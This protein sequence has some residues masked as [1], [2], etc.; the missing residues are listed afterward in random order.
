M[1]TLLIVEQST[2]TIG[3]EDNQGRLRN[4]NSNSSLGS[5]SLS[6]KSIPIDSVLL[7]PK[8]KRSNFVVPKFIPLNDWIRSQCSLQKCY[9][10]L[11]NIFS[12]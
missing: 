5:I 10:F 9:K 11:F 12:I 1:L 4:S 7:V 8:L 3:L 2:N 6:D